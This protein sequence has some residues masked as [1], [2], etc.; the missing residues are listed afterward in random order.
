MKLTHT[1]NNFQQGLKQGLRPELEQLAK[2]A[3]AAF[4]TLAHDAQFMRQC[5]PL[6]FPNKAE[7]WTYV[8]SH[9]YQDQAQQPQNVYTRE[10]LPF[11]T[12]DNNWLA[13]YVVAVVKD[14]L[15]GQVVD[16]KAAQEYVQH[17]ANFKHARN[18]YEQDLVTA[19]VNCILHHSVPNA[20]MQKEEV[21]YAAQS[22]PNYDIAFRAGVVDIMHRVGL[23]KHAVEVALEKNA[24]LWR[25]QTMK[26]AFDNLYYPHLHMA[27]LS[28]TPH[29]D[30][31]REIKQKHFNVWLQYRE[32]EYYQSHKDVIDELDLAT[33]N[34]KISP[35][36]SGALLQTLHKCGQVRREFLASADPE[37]LQEQPAAHEQTNDNIM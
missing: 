25:K 14:N 34:M 6:M 16:L 27:A 23:P 7:T 21:P 24:H 37:L 5:L 15:N 22:R 8:A 31:A 10:Y 1:Q 26:R 35:S 18:T 36:Q 28:D 30:Q 3:R 11:H 20:L 32:N 17:A 2:Q 13:H 12:R 19:L 9:D 4:G 33:E 29:W